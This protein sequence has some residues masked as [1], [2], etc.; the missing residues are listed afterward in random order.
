MAEA[1]FNTEGGG[2]FKAYSAG[3]NPAGQVNPFALEQISQLDVEV[4]L[5]SKSW[6]EFEGKAAPDLDFVITVCDN[7]AQE[8][9]PFFAGSPLHIHWGLPDPAAATGSDEDIRKEFGACFKELQSRIGYLVPRMN[10]EINAQ[11]TCNLMQ[12]FV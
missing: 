4:E 7:A 8:E 12:V 9:C 5:R 1:L 3:S 2:F 10:T 6:T 11:K